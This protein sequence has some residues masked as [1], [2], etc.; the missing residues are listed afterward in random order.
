LPLEEEVTIRHSLAHSDLISRSQVSA[1]FRKL[2]GVVDK[3][4]ESLKDIEGRPLDAPV[5]VALL[6]EETIRTVDAKVETIE[7]LLSLAEQHSLS[8]PILRIEGTLTDIATIMLKKRSLKKLS[9]SEQIANCILKV[10][11]QIYVDEEKCDGVQDTKSDSMMK[12]SF[13]SYCFSITECA[14]HLGPMAEPR[15][16]FAA[17]RRLETSGE[18]ELVLKPADRAL[19]LVIEPS[20]Q[21]LIKTN[22]LLDSFIETLWSTFAGH[23]RESARKV[24]C[25]H[26]VLE[27]VSSVPYIPATG[28]A[29]SNRLLKFQELTAQELEDGGSGIDLTSTVPYK[30]PD[31]ATK[32]LFYDTENLKAATS[33]LQGHID[34]SGEHGV[35]FGDNRFQDYTVLTLTKLC[36]GIETKRVGKALSNHAAFGKWKDFDFPSTYKAIYNLEK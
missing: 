34:S 10:G 2:R 4:Q 30:F 21:T 17:L 7:T 22:H 11:T 19:H 36:H 26:K 35:I 1:L 13:D 27:E 25:I 33:S 9:E 32:E 5:C 3:Y 15:H 28:G 6:V 31:S 12:Y 8:E 18:L 29:K 24:K 14:G 20:G 23:V 16:V